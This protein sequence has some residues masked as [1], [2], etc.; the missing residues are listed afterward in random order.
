MSRFSRIHAIC[1]Y[2]RDEPCK[3]CPAII[4]PEDCGRCRKGCYL[5]ARE[6][7]YIAKYGNPW[8]KRATR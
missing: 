8:G 1:D 4:E 3:G 6:V 7:Y 2:L 5:A